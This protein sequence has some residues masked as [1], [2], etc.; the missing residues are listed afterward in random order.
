ML[1][2]SRKPKQSI[3]ILL[4]NGEKI[5]VAIIAIDGKDVRPG[6]DAPPN[7]PVHR[8]EVFKAIMAA[9]VP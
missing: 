2:L 4:P 8:E 5:T 6:F 3:V 9:K 7:I 1:V